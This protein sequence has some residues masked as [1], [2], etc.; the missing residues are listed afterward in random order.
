LS[1][2]P[3]ITTDTF[4]SRLSGGK[5]VAGD[6][7]FLTLVLLV[8]DCQI[9]SNGNLI[10][11]KWTFAPTPQNVCELGY[12]LDC[13]T[14]QCW[15]SHCPHA[16]HLGND[17]RTI[18][19]FIFFCWYLVCIGHIRYYHVCCKASSFRHGE[20]HRFT[21]FNKMSAA[22]SK[23]TSTLIR[24]IALWCI[25]YATCKSKCQ[26]ARTFQISCTHDFIVLRN[27]IDNNDLVRWLFR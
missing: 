17:V 25:R 13:A 7:I 15:I 19:T 27:W 3:E 16:E 1:S 9:C 26:L 4:S 20:C 8:I 18:A 22:K 12:V 14:R 11:I 21:L 2:C 24:L 5:I 6:C 10:T 23:S